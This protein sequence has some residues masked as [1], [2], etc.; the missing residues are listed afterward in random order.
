MGHG[1]YGIGDRKKRFSCWDVNII[2]CDLLLI[3][4]DPIVAC[5]QVLRS[6]KYRINISEIFILSSRFDKQIAI[7]Y[8]QRILN[9]SE[10]FKLN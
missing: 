8:A 7:K 2:F 1:A 4:K 5:Y 3:I 6:E 9:K 10:K